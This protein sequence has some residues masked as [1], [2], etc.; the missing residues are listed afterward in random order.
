VAF[1][2][3]AWRQRARNPWFSSARDSALFIGFRLCP[4]RCRETWPLLNAAPRPAKKVSA[5]H[6]VRLGA[7]RVEMRCRM[8]L[9]VS[10][11]RAS[12]PPSAPRTT[13]GAMP[14]DRGCRAQSSTACCLDQHR[15]ASLV[16]STPNNR[17]RAC[18]AA[19]PHRHTCTC[20]PTRPA[21]T[22]AIL[23][24]R[25][26]LREEHRRLQVTCTT[27]SNSASLTS[28]MAVLALYA[29]AVDQHFERAECCSRGRPKSRMVSRSS[30]VHRNTDRLVP[31]SRNRAAHL[32]RLSP[33]CA[34]DTR[35][36]RAAD[37]SADAT[38]RR[39]A[40]AR[41]ARRR[42]GPCTETCPADR[43]RQMQAHGSVIRSNHISP[44]QLPSVSA[45]NTS[46]CD[47]IPTAAREKR[48]ASQTSGS[49]KRHDR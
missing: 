24:F 17:G 42:R 3:T 48:T 10:G 31:A 36:L 14:F 22:P 19:P 47:I 28:A 1:A 23:V 29:D 12:A 41:R 4:R 7:G 21:T 5:P 43:K 35:D 39:C 26:C 13:V 16:R 15:S 11:S 2:K 27:S 20:R 46:P 18:L 38:R 6:V 40:V 8:C 30:G 32:F 49:Q 44:S 33:R 9:R 37:A 45:R 34:P 25:H